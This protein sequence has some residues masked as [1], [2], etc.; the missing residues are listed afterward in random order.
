[1]VGT[2]IPEEMSD[3]VFET[4]ELAK[5]SGKISK[6]ANEVTK[7]L[8]RGQAKLIAIAKDVT[9]PEIVMH[10]PLIAKEKDVIC[11]EVASK[12]ELGAA[13]GLPIGTTAVAITEAGKGKANLETLKKQIKEL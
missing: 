3:K 5:T 11:V 10:L 13:A 4:I 6:G 2:Q 7:V 8:E 9:P 12:K 1:M